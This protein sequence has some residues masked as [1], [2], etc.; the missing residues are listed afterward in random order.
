ML[1]GE[2][3][4]PNPLLGM[5][6]PAGSAAKRQKLA[7]ANVDLHSLNSSLQDGRP[8]PKAQVQLLLNSSQAC[9]ELYDKHCKGRKDNTNCLHGLVPQPGSNRRKG[10]WQKEPEALQHLGADPSE[11]NRQVRTDVSSH[12]QWVWRPLPSCAA[13]AAPGSAKILHGLRKASEFGCFW[14]A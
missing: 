9:S 12:Q 5:P 4:S 2:Q 10:L 11:R 8:L 13:S 14:K 1:A 3:L 7:P 6:R